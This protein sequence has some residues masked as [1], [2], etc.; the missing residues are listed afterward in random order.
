MSRTC[1][2]RSL[3]GSGLGS[4]LVMERWVSVVL[5][6]R[7]RIRFLRLRLLAVAFISLRRLLLALLHSVRWISSLAME[8]T[9]IVLRLGQRFLVR[10]VVIPTLFGMVFT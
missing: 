10:V 1:T 4:N 2:Q 3:V 6:V 8:R 7:L 5:G 9:F